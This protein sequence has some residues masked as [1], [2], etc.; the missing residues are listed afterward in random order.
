[1]GGASTHEA[2]GQAVIAWR[3]VTVRY[4]GQV[5]VQNVSL[6][7]P[8]GQRVALV[9]PNGAGKTSLLRSALGLIPYT[10]TVL[11]GGVEVRRDPVAAR[12][13]VGYV[14][15]LLGFPP[16]L[17]AAEV[18]AFAQELRALAPDPAPVLGAAGLGSHGEKRVQE[19]SGGMLRRLG[20]A[21]AQMGDPPVLLL[22]EPTSF[23]DWDGE[24]WLVEWLQK[25][26]GKTVV[27]ASHQLR[28]L[29]RVVDRVVLLDGGQ[30]ARDVPAE[31]L[32]SVHW[33]EV[34][35]GTP[36]GTLPEGVQVLATQ[37]GAWHL[38]VPDHRLREVLEV[39]G[40]RPVRVHEPPPE[41]ILREVLG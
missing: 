19:L 21:L 20:V 38:R 26:T 1:M 9:G 35:V 10:G 36:I 11:V 30:V 31:R 13:Q 4:R 7:V 6:E 27:V 14:P 25:T 3:Q 23:L 29:E 12:R 37:N 33:L 41:R 16:N 39:V 28:G 2:G 5:V 40:E 8:T 18:V 32:R 15:Q 22:D 24:A 17:T 34:V